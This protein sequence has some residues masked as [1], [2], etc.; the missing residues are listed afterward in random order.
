LASVRTGLKWETGKVKVREGMRDPVME[1]F[2]CHTKQPR[3]YSTGCAQS[4]GD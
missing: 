4:L 3:L 2:I 1:V